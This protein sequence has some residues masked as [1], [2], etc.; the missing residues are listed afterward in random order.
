MDRQLYLLDLCGL[1]V[2]ITDGLPAAETEA[3]VRAL[4]EQGIRGPCRV[5]SEADMERRG[6]IRRA[7]ANQYADYGY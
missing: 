4:R 2:V 6:W 1:H 7:R 3:V 5:I